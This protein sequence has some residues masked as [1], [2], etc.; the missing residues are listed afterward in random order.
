MTTAIPSTAPS[1][2]RRRRVSWVRHGATAARFLL[3]LGFG[4]F[5]LNIFLNFIPPP[6]PSAFPE[7]AMAFSTA[8]VETG[9][10][11][12]LI[13]GTQLIA[14][15]CL[16][17]NRFVPLA[18]VLLAPFLVNSIAFH[19]FLEP[20]GLPTAIVF[21]ALTLFLAWTHREAYRPLMR[22]RPEATGSG[23]TNDM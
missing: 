5:G 19:I 6:P 21:T 15:V 13:A 12:S 18:L 8:L 1:T 14:A 9:Y 20:S 16:L 22:P 10:M 11:M 2:G 3:G 23:G 7:G 4:V 17:S